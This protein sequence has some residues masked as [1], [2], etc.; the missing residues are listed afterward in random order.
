MGDLGSRRSRKRYIVC[1]CMFGGCFV[2]DSLVCVATEKFPF[3][4]PEADGTFDTKVHLASCLFLSRSPFLTLT[5]LPFSPFR[6]SR[7]SPRLLVAALRLG[8]L[9]SA[10][11]SRSQGPHTKNNPRST[12]ETRCG[13]ICHMSACPM[14]LISIGQLSRCDLIVSRDVSLARSRDVSMVT[15][16]TVEPVIHVVTT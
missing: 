6:S 9:A 2:R 11:S 12:G 3:W 7:F 14:C 5:L 16:S 10:P 15:F 8:P 1:C 13:E 4:E